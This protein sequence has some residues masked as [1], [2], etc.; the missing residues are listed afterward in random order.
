MRINSPES[1]PCTIAWK[2]LG[3]DALYRERLAHSDLRVVF[4]YGQ[5][6]F[7][8]DKTGTQGFVNGK[9]VEFDRTVTKWFLKFISKLEN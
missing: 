6:I 1:D 2:N 9:P 7:A 8:F 5:D 4:L 3:I